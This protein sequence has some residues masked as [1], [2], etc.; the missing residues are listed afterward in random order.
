M[1]GTATGYTPQQIRAAYDFGN[2][3]DPNYTNRGDGQ[4][5]AI[6][7]PY[8]TPLIQQSVATF[9]TTYGLPAQTQITFKSSTRAAPL[10]RPTR[11]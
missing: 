5:I 3:N 1:F 9:S 6:V 11:A 8:S 2:L 10:P 4:A 7:I